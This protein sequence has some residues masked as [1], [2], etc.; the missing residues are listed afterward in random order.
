VG[1]GRGSNCG[2]KNTLGDSKMREPRKVIYKYSNIKYKICI[3]KTH[4]DRSLSVLAVEWEG[5]S[6]CGK[7]NF[8]GNSETREPREVIYKYSNM[9]YEI[10][11]SK[12]HQDWSLS[13][14]AVVWARPGKRF[15]L[16]DSKFSG[17]FENAGAL[18]SHI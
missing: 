4:Q 13:V 17:G 9:K 18:K 6:N 1:R 16:R 10:Y 2:T 7:Q 3:S 14:L 15:K 8:W 5:G 11:I 12:T